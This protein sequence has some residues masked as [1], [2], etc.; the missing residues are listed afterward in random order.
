MLHSLALK[1]QLFVSISVSVNSSEKSFRGRVERDF[2]TEFDN[3]EQLLYTVN[4]TKKNKYQII[5]RS[6]GIN[7]GSDINID[8]NTES[9]IHSV[10]TIKT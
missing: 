5:R 9:S 8:I 6:I 7:I 3:M 10:A 2:F 4:S 1:Q